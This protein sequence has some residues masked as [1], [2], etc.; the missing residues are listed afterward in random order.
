[1]TTDAMV[2]SEVTKSSPGMPELELTPRR[3]EAIAQPVAGE[4]AGHH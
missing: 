3:I 4:I 1:M 2:R